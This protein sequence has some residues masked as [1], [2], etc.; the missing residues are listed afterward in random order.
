MRSQNSLITTV[1]EQ[2]PVGKIPLGR[3][4][5]RRKVTVKRDVEELGGGSNWKD[6]AMDREMAEESVARRD[7]LIN[8][9]PPLKKN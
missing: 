1:L 7:G 5:P 2:N 9:I 3:P 8:L 6:L 4:K